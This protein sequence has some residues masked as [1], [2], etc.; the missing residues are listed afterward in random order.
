MA[1]YLIQDTTLTSLANKVKEKTGKTEKLTIQNMLTEMDKLADV[2]NDTVTA[3]TM[4]NGTKAHNNTG[5]AITGN[6]PS[7][8]AKT[9]TP[10]TSSQTGIAAGTYA[11]GAVTINPI[12][13]NWIEGPTTIEAGDYPICGKTT[14]TKV[15]ATSYTDIGMNFTANKAGTYRFKW[16]CMKPAVTFGGSGNPGT[17]LFLNGVQQYENTSFSDNVNYNTVD[18]AMNVGDTVSVQARHGGSMYATYVYGVNVCIKWDNPNAFFT[19]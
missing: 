13:S 15:T 9:I 6:I 1:E 5:Q 19:D 14:S 8:S 7:Q 17:A 16:C 12:P 3:A 2:S 10:S 11:S 18:V 4:L